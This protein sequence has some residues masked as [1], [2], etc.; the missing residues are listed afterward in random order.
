MK[1]LV[2]F[3]T[4]LSFS[5]NSQTDTIRRPNHIIIYDQNKR[6]P[7]FVSYSILCKSKDI[8]YSRTRLDFY[9]EKKY[10]TS[11][12][13]D[14]VKNEYDKG[15]MMPYEAVSCDS[16]IARSSF[17]Y[18]NCAMQHE[19]LNRN[20]WRMLELIEKRLG[21]HNTIY[22]EIHILFENKN[23]TK[24]GTQIPSKFIKKIWINGVLK[25]QYG[26]LNIAPKSNNL[27]DY[28]IH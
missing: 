16:I 19:K 9:R 15:H 2:F 4:L 10:R 22:V 12:N 6:Q 1:C 13:Q 8:K 25:R 14:Y 27:K 20:V 18:L 21:E 26:F 3:L 23:F 28:E 11:I 5:V 7:V 17:S 24:S